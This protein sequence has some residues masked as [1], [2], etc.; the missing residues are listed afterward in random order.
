[1]NKVYFISG[2][3]DISQHEFTT[4][5]RPQLNEAV[6]NNG[7]FVVGDARGVDSYA[8]KYLMDKGCD[9]TVY[10]MFDKPRNNF[11]G[12][13]TKGGFE[14]DEVRDS[15]MTCDSD[16]DILWLRP[17]DEQQKKLGKKYDPNFVNG[18]MNNMKRRLNL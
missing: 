3:L 13:K 12:Y 1:M 4:H 16:A 9:V 8:Q 11:G 10:H 6:V 5:Y 2:H 17:A 18:T 7:H 15:A 14:S